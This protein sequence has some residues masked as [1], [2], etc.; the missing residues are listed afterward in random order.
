MN[1]VKFQVAY[2]Y[3]FFHTKVDVGEEELDLV[4]S[5]GYAC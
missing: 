3:L 5:V 1:R 4:C 2:H